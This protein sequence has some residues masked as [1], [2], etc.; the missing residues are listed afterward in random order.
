MVCAHH[1]DHTNQE[2]VMGANLATRF[3]WQSF[4]RVVLWGVFLILLGYI[5]LITFVV[6]TGSGPCG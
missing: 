6:I 1:A 5:A 3:R 2:Y 4:A